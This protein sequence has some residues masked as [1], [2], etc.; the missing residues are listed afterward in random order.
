MN[1]KDKPRTDGFHSATCPCCGM[2]ATERDA[3]LCARVAE[4]EGATHREK[5]LLARVVELT[6]RVRVLEAEKSREE[7]AESLLARVAKL[8]Y[9][10]AQ[11]RAAF[12]PPLSG[13]EVE[14]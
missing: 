14:K 13:T 8:K 12:Y 3:T 2:E 4:L 1:D 7:D 11:F 10:Y 9:T 5:L 6:E